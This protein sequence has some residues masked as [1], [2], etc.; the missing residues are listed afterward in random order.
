MINWSGLSGLK[1]MAISTFLLLL[2]LFQIISL[3]HYTGVIKVTKILQ[4]FVQVLTISVIHMS[5]QISNFLTL[6]P[7]SLGAL[8]YPKYYVV[9]SS[10]YP[11]CF[12]IA[13]SEWAN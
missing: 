5:K 4:L 11:T 12:I 3:S 6:S 13:L 1:I 10:Y 2:L 9:M 7:T 8:L